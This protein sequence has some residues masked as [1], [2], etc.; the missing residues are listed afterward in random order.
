MNRSV[1]GS[2]LLRE[3]VAH[4]SA[5][6][7]NGGRLFSRGEIGWRAQKR[8]RDIIQVYISCAGRLLVDVGFQT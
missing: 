5:G 8:Q 2:N 3:V 1:T 4:T 6:L 7:D